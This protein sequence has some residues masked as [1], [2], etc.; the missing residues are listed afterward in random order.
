MITY[1]I[2]AKE[3]TVPEWFAK[4]IKFNSKWISNG[5]NICEVISFNPVT[6]LLRVKVTIKNIGRDDTVFEEDGWNLQHTIWGFET[7]DYV[8][9]N[10][11]H[12]KYTK[13]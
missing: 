8:L 7:K 5:N 12:Y 1:N 6:N 4:G 13:Q 10:E 3:I 11:T 2:W 9:K